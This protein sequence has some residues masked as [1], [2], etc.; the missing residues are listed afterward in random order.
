MPL[1]DPAGPSFRRI[2]FLVFILAIYVG[3]L[4]LTGQ[5]P[6]GLGIQGPP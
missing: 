5:G 1:L 6:G 3:A 2:W 4:R